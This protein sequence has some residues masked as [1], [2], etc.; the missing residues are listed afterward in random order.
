LTTGRVLESV[1]NI[2]KLVLEEPRTDQKKFQS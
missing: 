2:L 1:A